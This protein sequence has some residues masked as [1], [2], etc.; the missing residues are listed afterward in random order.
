MGKGLRALQRFQ[1]PPPQQPHPD[2]A[3]AVGA[4]EAGR[5]VAKAGVDLAADRDVEVKPAVSLR[6]RDRDV[7]DPALRRGR[8]QVLVRKERDSKT[9]K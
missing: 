6:Q 1:E 8:C 7:A 4:A 2:R 5:V 9:L 3:D